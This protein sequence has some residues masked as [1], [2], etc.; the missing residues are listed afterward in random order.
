MPI[1][2]ELKPPGQ[3]QGIKDGCQRQLCRV[4]ARAARSARPRHNAAY[5]RQDR[6][7][8]RGLMFGMVTDNTLYFRVDDH[9]QAVFKEAASFP[10]LSYE[11]KGSTI[12]LSFWRAPERLFDEPDELVT[13][14]R[15]ALAAARRVAAKRERTAPR[16]KSKPQPIEGKIDAGARTTGQVLGRCPV[17]HARA[18]VALLSAMPAPAGC[19]FEQR[20]EEVFRAASVTR[21]T[22][23]RPKLRFSQVVGRSEDCAHQC[24]TRQARS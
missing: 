14:A 11:K 20:S 4:P 9:N 17:G 10:P 22:D 12:D 15:A 8:L 3:G 24:G 16:R 6:H 21:F 13:W 1:L 18:S 19:A 23:R 5:V 2:R 7:V